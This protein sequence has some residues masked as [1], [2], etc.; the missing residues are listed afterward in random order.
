[1][2]TKNEIMVIFSFAMF[3]Y[4]RVCGNWDFGVADFSPNGSLTGFWVSHVIGFNICPKTGI[5][6]P[7]VRHPKENG[8]T[9]CETS[10]TAGLWSDHHPMESFE[11]HAQAWDS[12]RGSG[13][14]TNPNS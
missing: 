7:T 10:P 9:N 1:M 6:A 13:I 11:N 3:D 12:I 14:Q 8:A 4:Q 5:E 2:E